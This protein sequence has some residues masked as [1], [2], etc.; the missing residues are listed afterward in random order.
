LADFPTGIF[1]S[2]FRPAWWLRNAHAQTMFS[3]FFRRPPRVVRRRETLPLADGDFLDMDW[4]Y[5]ASWQQNHPLALVVHGLTGSS[6]SLYVRGLQAALSVRGWASAAL[7]CRGADR[8]NNLPLAYH[9]GSSADLRQALE[10]VQH[11][12]P[13][14]PRAIVGYCL[15]GNTT[16]K[17]LGE[18]TSD[19]LVFAGVAVSVPLL[20]SLCADRMDKGFSRIYRRRFMSELTAHWEEKAQHL[21]CSGN[22]AAA[23][24]VRDRLRCGPF[25]SFWQFDND[26][27]APLHGFQDARDYY[28]QCSARQLLH[29]ITTPTLVIQA[30]D[31]P[32][33][34]PGVL[35]DA[36]EL[37]PAVHFELSRR[38]G[39]VGFIEGGTPRSPHYYLERRIP[40]FLQAC[41]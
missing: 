1:A 24:C 23:R 25:H 19:A 39:H 33:M 30:Q 14:A 16:L 12:H 37:S 34:M 2:P 27:V 26:L 4:H 22:A 7:N 13:R 28:D 6:E 21:E 35:P 31:D 38:G 8:Q 3:H 11:R 29:R 41:L 15:G 32:F 18:T 36:R 5:P 20:L 9:A 10:Y 17:L 40:D